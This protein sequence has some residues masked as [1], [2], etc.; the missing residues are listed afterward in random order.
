MVTA[1][2]AIPEAVVTV[3]T[4]NSA[5]D[6]EHC[7][8]SLDAHFPPLGERRA[9]VHVVD[10]ASRDDTRAIVARL[11]EECPWLVLHEPGEN[12]G[13]GPGNNVVLRNLKARA[14][15][16]LNA[17]AWLVA[18]SLTPA[19]DYLAA[20]PKTGVIG[21]PLVFPDG[22]PQSHAFVSSAWHRWL[23]LLMGLRGLAKRLVGFAPTRKL[24]QLMP[25]AR[26][27]V[28][29]HGMP[30]LDL[31]DPDALAASATGED[32]P[33]DWV[34][35]AAMVLSP[36][37]V[38]ASGGFDPKIFLYG[39]DED[40]CIQAHRLGFAVTTLRTVPIVHK[41]GWGGDGGFC[42]IVA[43]MKYDSL[44][45]FIAKNVNGGVNR[46]MMRALLPLYVYGR[47]IGHFLRKAG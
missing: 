43:Q 18:D 41:L 30:G 47:H 26:N 33:A 4:H 12:L 7:I 19:L 10:N 32:R 15:V 37:F 45:Y 28:A 13:F 3:V 8:R 9:L 2:P 31:A 16:L 20:H 35:G 34:A 29:N 38:A 40:L 42:P 27:F 5:A 25:F 39:E 6:I 21:L 22:S 24:M 1:V 44:K 36:E 11:A 46:A 17:D 23:L 14:H